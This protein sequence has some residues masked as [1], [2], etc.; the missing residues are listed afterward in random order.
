[1]LSRPPRPAPI[2]RTPA[3]VAPTA[4]T[5]WQPVLLR[6]NGIGVSYDGLRALEAV[7][8]ELRAGRVHALIGPN[9]SGKSTLLRV[10]A[11]DLRPDAGEVEVAGVAQPVR[12]TPQ[13]R[14]RAGVVRTPQRTALLPRTTP[15]RQV[16][17]GARGGSRPRQAVLRHLLGTPSS[18]TA[19]GRAQRTVAAAL[20][21]TRLAQVADADPAALTVG[22]QRL[23]Q[24]ARAVA[25]GAS[26]LLLDE[27][28]AGM[29]ADERATLRS[30]LRDL[31]GNGLA[32]LLVEHDMRLVNAVAERVTVLDAGRVIAE[33]PPAAVRTDDA[34][35]IAYLG[36]PA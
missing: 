18:R 36:A 9:G 32:V 1:V 30:V 3:D 27:P 19:A 26:V 16:E 13:D 22:E 35:R 6:A 11:G 8:L 33:G 10:L 23:L 12:T 34:V 24:V 21:R 15:A 14:V 5:A 31:A 7:D 2:T 28:A 25:T 20:V 4:T 29:T 17:V